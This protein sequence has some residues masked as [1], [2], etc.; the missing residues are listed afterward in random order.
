MATL[1]EWITK[2]KSWYNSSF[3]MACERGDRRYAEGCIDALNCIK[4]AIDDNETIKPFLR[5]KLKELECRQ[6]KK[7]D[8]ETEGF[9][10]GLSNVYRKA[11]NRLLEGESEEASHKIKKKRR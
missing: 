10:S 1:D 2:E 7:L 8:D 4:S 11:L 9:L 3:D 6:E 5:H